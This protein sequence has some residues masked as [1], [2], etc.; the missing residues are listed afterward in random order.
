MQRRI[1]MFLPW[2]VWAGCRSSP[3]NARAAAWRRLQTSLASGNDLESI[4]ACEDYLAGLG[5][6]DLH[7]ARTE[8][9]RNAYRM[10]FVRWAASLPGAPGAAV[11]AR[12]ERFKVLMSDSVKEEVAR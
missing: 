1:L 12:L 6:A 9:V 8:Q 5:G 4:R 7:S 10:V 11:F 2:L 3:G